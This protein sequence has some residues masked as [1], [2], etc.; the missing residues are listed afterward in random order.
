MYFV[1]RYN[2]QE[3]LKEVE[4]RLHASIPS[5]NND[6]SLPADIQARLAGK[7]AAYGQARGGGVSEE[8]IERLESI[9]HIIEELAKLEWQAQTSFLMLKRKWAAVSMEA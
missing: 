2:E 9:K 3:L 5:L 4:A 1:C 8:V 6:M 7:G